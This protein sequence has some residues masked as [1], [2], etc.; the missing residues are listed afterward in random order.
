MQN[1]GNVKEAVQPAEEAESVLASV[2]AYLVDLQESGI[3]ELPLAASPLVSA[4]ERDMLLGPPPELLSGEEIVETLDSIRSDLGDCHR[5]QLG[6]TR[7]SLVFGV[8]NPNAR[9]VFVGEGPGRDEDLQGEPFV[10]EAGKLLTRIIEAMG[11]K[12]SD[13]YICNVIKCRPPQNRDPLPSEIEACS[14][15]MLRQ[16]KAINPL[17]IVALGKFAAQTLLA[18]KTPI[19]KLRGTFHDYHGIPLMPTFHPAALL[20]DPALKR[21]VWEDMK[22]VM[23]KMGIEPPLQKGGASDGS[24]KP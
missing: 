19:S 21:E 20:R 8:G 24:T 10:G 15:F 17:M 1:S 13:V 9:L 3:D 5:C 22:Q 11:L 6:A 2:R 23:K 4:A 14:S 7:T 18:A 16:V 12:R